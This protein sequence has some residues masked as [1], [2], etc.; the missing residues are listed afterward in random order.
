MAKLYVFGIGGTGSRVIKALSMLLASGVK[1]NN[2]FDTIVPIIIDPDTANGDLNRTGDILLKYQNIYKEIGTNND[3]FGTKISTLSQLTDGNVANLT[4]NFKFSVDG[5]DEK[6]GESIDYNGLDDSN[7]ALIDLLFSEAN[8]EADMTVGFKGN[9]NIGSIV[10]N[11]IVESTEYNQFANSFNEGDAI[12]IIS[13]IFGGTGASGFP[14][15]LKNLRQDTADIV[16]SNLISKSKIGA[17]T[18]LPYFKIST[19][20]DENKAIDSSTFFSKA[21]SALSYYEHA[22]F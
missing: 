5:S 14:L 2:G 17:I 9:P 4:N 22:I 12:F 21:K 13:S 10:L 18:Y 6:F 1:L 3:L 15:L 20:Q 16:N 11:K 8:I 19:P 7:K